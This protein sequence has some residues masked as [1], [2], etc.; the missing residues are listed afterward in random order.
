MQQLVE[1]KTYTLMV[2][3]LVECTNTSQVRNNCDFALNRDQSLSVQDF[4]TSF[5]SFEVNLRQRIDG[6][7]KLTNHGQDLRVLDIVYVF[8]LSSWQEG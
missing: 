4:K 5:N 7:D 3:E 2:T 1:R 8:L 6:F